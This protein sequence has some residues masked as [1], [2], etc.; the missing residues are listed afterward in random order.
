MLL[1]GLVLL[2]VA[3]SKSFGESNVMRGG[4]LICRTVQP[5]NE[6]CDAAC[7]KA[8]MVCTGLTLIQLPEQGCGDETSSQAKCRC[9]AINGR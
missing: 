1:A 2:V 4:G 3:A 5:Q 7:A 9:C 8:D 6:S